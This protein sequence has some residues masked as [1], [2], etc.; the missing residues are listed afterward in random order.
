MDGDPPNRQTN[1]AGGKMPIKLD[2]G[3]GTKKRPGTVGVDTASL[4]GVDIVA[5]AH[6]IPLEDGV[7]DE[8]YLSHILEHVPSLVE[9][10]AEVWRLCR[11]GAI[12]H[13]WSPHASCS[14]YAWSDPTHVRALSTTTF[15]YWE[16]GSP[17]GYYSTAK[18]RVIERELHFRIA[19][20]Q[21]EHGGRLMEAATRMLS[22]VLDP[23]ANVNRTAQII[24]ERIWAPWVGFEEFYMRLECLK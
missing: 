14:Y 8:V 3:C 21:V 9:V 17:L 19:G 6:S 1:Q 15:D 18:F 5:P 12:V 24:C 23:L 13:V 20:Q 22:R 4:P 2:I 11:P 16:P 10:M 7:A